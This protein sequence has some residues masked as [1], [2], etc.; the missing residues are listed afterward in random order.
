MQNEAFS[1]LILTKSSH[2]TSLGVINVYEF[3]NFL[4]LSVY[5]NMVINHEQC[6]FIIYKSAAGKETIFNN[7]QNQLN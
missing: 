5:H 6:I 1:L 7:Y 2:N 3:S 4:L